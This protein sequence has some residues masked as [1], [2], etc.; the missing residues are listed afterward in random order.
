[1]AQH[2]DLAEAIELAQSFALLVRQR[3]SD[4]LDCW[5]EQAQKS[6][7][8]PFHRFAKR[9]REDYDAVKAGVTLP[10]SNGQT[11]WADQ[12][13]EDVEATDVWSCWD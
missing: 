2:P 10:W 6:Q 9:L 11:C 3:Q 7:L 13:V 12:S 1:M 8:S 4:Q 5:L